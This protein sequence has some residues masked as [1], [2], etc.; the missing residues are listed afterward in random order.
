MAL[1]TLAGGPGSPI[2]IQV[3]Y[4]VNNRRVNAILV[5]NN[6]DRPQFAGFYG[7]PDPTTGAKP[8]YGQVFP[9]SATPVSFDVRGGGLSITVPAPDSSDPWQTP[10]LVN[11]G[12]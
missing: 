5:T 11:Y 3:D 6:S 9:V 12:L 10:E 8:L 1:A 4:N 2:T 7:D